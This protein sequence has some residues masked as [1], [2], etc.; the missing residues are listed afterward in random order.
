MR[1]STRRS[2]VFGFF[3][4]LLLLLTAAIVWR[5]HSSAGLST[6]GL[7]LGIYCLSLGWTQL[8]A[9]GEGVEDVRAATATNEH[10]DARL[11]LPPNPEFGRL[12]AE[13][14]AGEEQRRSIDIYWMSV[15]VILFLLIHIGRTGMHLSTLGL[16][17]PGL[18]T[19]G[20]VISAALLGALVILPC[21][22][23][24]RRLTRPL[25]RAAWT[26]LLAA[27]DSPERLD[28]GERLTRLWLHARLRFGVRMRI[29][30]GSLSAALWDIMESGL[31]VVAFLVAFNPIWGFS[32]YFNTENW[33]SGFWDKVTSERTDPWRVAMTDAV[34]KAYP[35]IDRAAPLRRRPS[36]SRH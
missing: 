3:N 24:W 21:R 35:G 26:N 32:W 15:L 30:R 5:F 18:A 8:I 2:R 13:A 22:L 29:A 12:R 34:E 11:G 4:G 10:P 23:L 7:A 16:I 28:L 25:E 1:G 27:G 20:D 19:L 36:R 6:A 31:P 33:A 9:P 14:I 17:T